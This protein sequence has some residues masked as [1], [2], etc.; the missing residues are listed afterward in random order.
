M[1]CASIARVHGG[2][3]AAEELRQCIHCDLLAY[4]RRRLFPQ[5]NDFY[6]HGSMSHLRDSRNENQTTQVSRA[7]RPY[8]QRS[9]I[10]VWGLAALD[11]PRHGLSPPV[12]IQKH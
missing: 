10:A 4:D 11:R 9:G 8:S 12:I 3:R 2:E 1:L 5:F 6:V 7:D